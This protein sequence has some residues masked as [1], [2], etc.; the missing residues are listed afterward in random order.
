M[1]DVCLFYI[2]IIGTI[3]PFHKDFNYYIDKGARKMAIKIYVVGMWYKWKALWFKFGVERNEH[4]KYLESFMVFLHRVLK[5]PTAGAT[6]ADAWNLLRELYMLRKANKWGGHNEIDF[7]VQKRNNSN[8]SKIKLQFNSKFKSNNKTNNKSKSKSK[9]KIKNKKKNN[10][11]KK[12]DTVPLPTKPQSTQKLIEQRQ[13]RKQQQLIQQRQ[14][15]R[16]EALKKPHSAEAIEEY[17]IDWQ[18]QT[19]RKII[20]N[21]WTTKYNKWSTWSHIEGAPSQPVNDEIELCMMYV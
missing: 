3:Y 17:R 21:E 18:R 11:E 9:S 8:N 4:S 13:Q 6:I 10:I 12:S 7:S 2:C 5:H 15:Q 1:Y 16:E 14:Q 19:K 20:P